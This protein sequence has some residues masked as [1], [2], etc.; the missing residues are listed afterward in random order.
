LGSFTYAGT[1]NADPLV[2]KYVSGSKTMYILTVPDQ[3]ARTNTYVL[4]LG[5][6][7]ANIYTLTKGAD[8]A[9]KQTVSTNNGMLSVSVSETPI[10]IEEIN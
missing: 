9:A 4:D 10:I 7:K 6:A 8:D 2:D 1:I 5:K 3:K